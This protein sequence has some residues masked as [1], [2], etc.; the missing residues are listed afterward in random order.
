M[1]LA[2]LLGFATVGSGIGLV[3]TSAWLIATAALHPSIADLQVAI[4]G[5][6]FFGIARGVFRYL[7][8]YVTHQVTFRLLARL[9]V[10]FYSAVE[11]LAP[12]GLLRH[13][14]GDLLTRA[15]ADIETLQ[16]FY[17]RVL[18]P[19]FVALLVV[20]AMWAFAAAFDARLANALVGLL[21][22]AGAGVPLLTHLLSRAPGRR[23]IAIR[24][25][26]NATLVEGIQG[27]ADLLALGRTETWTRRV[28]ALS[29]ELVRWQRRMA[30]VTGLHSALGSLL[31]SLAAIAVLLIGVPLVDSGKLDG[32]YLA[33]L[34]L[35]AI[36]AF[37]AV[38]P[39]PQAAQHLEASL[40]AARR[41]LDIG[42]WSLGDLSLRGVPSEARDDEAIPNAA[43]QI[44][45]GDCFV[46]PPGL[47]AKTR[48]GLPISDLHSL[49]SITHLRFRYSPD[50]PYALD[51]IT[52]DLPVGGRLAI[53]GSSGAG[54]S[55]LVNVLLRFW[56]Y[57]G[58][59]CLEGRELRD[60]AEEEVRAK[61]GVVAQSTFLFN[62]T[63]RENLLLARPDASAAD[64]ERV[65][66]QAQLDTF[67]RSLP[68]GYDT[69]IGEQGLNL[70]GGERQRLAI[71]RALLQDAPILILDE[72]T[73]NLD[74]LT[75]RAVM[76]AIKT[77]MQGRT[78]LLITHRLVGLEDA[79]EILVLRA[80]RIVERGRHDELMQMR[81][82]YYRMR[83]LGNCRLQI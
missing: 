77:L 12:A 32:V 78:T 62:A 20:L 79:D 61:I 51:D 71:A 70:S 41:L 27:L 8:R 37:E 64:L 57:E 26:L 14:S 66:A 6:R 46:A 34:T 55:S 16:N 69:W 83:E 17:G 74:A 22:L 45:I 35:A 33:V 65:V 43:A 73:A 40:Q 29:D 52:F 76:Q 21:L 36:A 24:A 1:A 56:H 67:V 42:D 11:P 72:A 38:L 63:L 44:N 3:A 31:T 58:S 23:L 75:E 15:V 54:K 9:R 18:A 60:M 80:G 39:L 48:P 59:I 49:I 13:R 68:N 4:V 10:R 2:A 47:L 28:H 19:P 7:E 25:D 50:A 53:V 82:I 5:V 81:G 30:W